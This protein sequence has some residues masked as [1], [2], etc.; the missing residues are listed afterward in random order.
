MPPALNVYESYYLDAFDMTTDYAYY[1]P[2]TYTGGGAYHW[3]SE[4]S[5]NLG[6]PETIPF[7]CK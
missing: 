7:P 4:Y 5:V 6:Y 1:V 2:D 3:F